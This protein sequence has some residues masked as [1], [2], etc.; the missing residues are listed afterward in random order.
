MF[1]RI[2]ISALSSR[3]PVFMAIVALLRI[4]FKVDFRFVSCSL[5]G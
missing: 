4:E 1:A 5:V 3:S 2:T